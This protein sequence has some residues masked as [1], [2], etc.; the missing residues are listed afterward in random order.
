MKRTL[1]ILM[2][3]L[4]CLWGCGGAVVSSR[5]PVR[6]MEFIA[7]TMPTPQCHAST[8][9]EMGGRPAVAWFGGEYEGSPDTRI[10]FSQMENGRWTRARVVANGIMPDGKR[11]ACWNPVL[12]HAHDGTLML[13]YKAGPNP[14]EWWGMLAA[15][16]DLGAS[17]T[18]PVRLPEGYVGPVR[19]HP[20]EFQDG[21][22]LCPSS[23][24]DHG[25]QV[26]MER[27]PD[28][29]TTWTKT[30]PLNDTA[31]IGAIQPAILVEPDG[32]LLA[33]GRT[34]QGRMFSMTSV[35]E[36]RSWST[37]KLLDFVCSN[38]GIDG[39]TLAD[40]RRVVVYNH[41][42]NA[43]GD[44]R[45]GRDT[46]ALAVSMDGR[47]WETG[48]LIETEPGAEFSYPSVTQTG[49]GLIHV[50]YTWKRHRIRH[51]VVDPGLL[52][53]RPFRGSEWE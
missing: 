3:G 9:I 1:L 51:V 8:I 4:P 25:W 34:K 27:T 44:W 47:K 17:W 18:A 21:A 35:D 52:N 33:L 37:M 26:W 10:W 31:S 13:F 45:V 49:D 7:D 16:G 22:L 19:N 50:T 46:L 38:S 6:S 42:R 48:C 5:Y 39:V 20:V 29:G 41:A 11:F 40:G 2:C 23:T 14:R 28:K 36:G 15:S 30:G 12:H 53:G 24:E 32:G 43:A